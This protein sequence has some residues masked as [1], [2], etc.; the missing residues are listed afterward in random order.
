MVRWKT[1]S[2][3]VSAKV[4]SMIMTMLLKTHENRAPPEITQTPTCSTTTTSAFS[5]NIVQEPNS[6]L[7]HVE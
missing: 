6:R 5:T 1:R 2:E 7:N 3:R 4:H